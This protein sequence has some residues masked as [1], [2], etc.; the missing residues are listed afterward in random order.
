MRSLKKLLV[1]TASVILT[2]PAAL[3]APAS[4]ADA[5]VRVVHP[6]ESIQDAVDA[7]S[8]GD[9]VRVDP[10]TYRESVT[11]QTDGITV[12]AD[13]R[14]TLRP[15]EDGSGLCNEPDETIGF[16]VI[17]ADIDFNTGE[18]TERV[19]DVTIMG[20]R[21][22]GFGS[23]GV[24]GFGTMNL[25]VSWLDALRNAEYGAASFDGVGTTFV[26]N[27]ARGS[28][29]AGLYIGDSPHA[30][31]LVAMNR[32]RNNL[33][34]VLVR[35]TH[36][37]SVVRN[38]VSNNCLGVFVLDD[39]QPGGSGDNM[40]ARNHV[41][42]NNHRC[43]IEEVPSLPEVGGGGILLVGSQHNLVTRNVVRGNRGD[44]PFS[45]GIVLVT[46]P[47]PS[48]DGSFSAATDNVVTHNRLSRN[49]P[50][51]IVEDEASSPNRFADNTCDRSIPG[52][53]CGHNADD[54]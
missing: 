47:A 29:E 19:A 1:L 18:Y 37:V 23:S 20:F 46:T 40:V 10:G 24:F 3:T 2:A 4:A 9:T 16:C 45:G 49:R 36:D 32:T 43:L 13:G 5:H 53:L 50:A 21:V 42:A 6:G 28:G 39:G 27:A 41:W 48:E 51:D 44:T 34:G 54:G 12:R 11:I 7:S 14:V 30:D 38:M 8:A 33:F 15:P 35:H 26:H 52:G 22:V 31:A 25:T 17:P